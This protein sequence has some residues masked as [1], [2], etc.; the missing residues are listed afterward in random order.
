MS[1]TLTPLTPLSGLSSTSGTDYSGMSPDEVDTALNS[2]MTAPEINQAMGY[3]YAPSTTPTSPAVPTV[4]S[5]VPLTSAP[6]TAA[7]NATGVL[8]S[9]WGIITGN[10]ENG[11]FVILGLLLIAAGIF[12]FKSTQT[13]V[14]TVGK[15]GA[16]AAEVAAA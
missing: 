14:S 13:V 2:P 3:N 11:I 12:S 7:Q 6:P 10:V 4:G 8:S 1:G 16:K 9:I 15:V 5:V